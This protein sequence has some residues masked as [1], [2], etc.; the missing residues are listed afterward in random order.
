MKK[1]L[2]G[3]VLCGLLVG[4]SGKYATNDKQQ[5]LESR[6]GSPLVVPPPLTRANMSSFYELPTPE[7]ERK[8]SIVPPK[9]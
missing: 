9:P 8:V 1:L 7:G 6:N 4:C 3:L 2:W 5:Y